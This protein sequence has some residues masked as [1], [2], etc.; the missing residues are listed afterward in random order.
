MLTLINHP[1]LLFETCIIIYLQGLKRMQMWIEGKYLVSLIL[2]TTLTEH[3]SSINSIY[4]K[5]PM[6]GL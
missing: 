6:S 5:N 2:E 4:Y 1:K 3:S